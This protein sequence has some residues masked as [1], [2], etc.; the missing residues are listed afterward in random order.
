MRDRPL[1]I[2]V[3]VH[4]SLF[5]SGGAYVRLKRLAPPVRKQ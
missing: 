2:F 5:L 3:G 4:H 1:A